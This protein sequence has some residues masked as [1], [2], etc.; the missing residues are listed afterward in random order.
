MTLHAHDIWRGCA[1]T[2][3]KLF[4]HINM[5]KTSYAELHKLYDIAD[6]FQNTGDYKQ[7]I[8]IY[9]TANNNFELYIKSVWKSTFFCVECFEDCNDATTFVRHKVSHTTYVKI[10]IPSTLA[11][12]E[13]KA[14]SIVTSEKTYFRAALLTIGEFFDENLHSLSKRYNAALCLISHNN[15]NLN[16]SD[17]HKTPTAGIFPSFMRDDVKKPKVNVPMFRN[18]F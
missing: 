2:S 7:A 5:I 11:E 8:Q 17:T 6:V 4:E 3:G 18:T 9:Q 14:D 1:D 13:L 10:K 12:M 15:T 16:L